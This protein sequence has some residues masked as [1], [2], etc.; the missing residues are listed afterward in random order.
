MRLNMNRKRAKTRWLVAGLLML[1]AWLVPGCAG[2][3]GPVS[4]QTYADVLPD[5]MSRRAGFTGF[6]AEGTIAA[7]REGESYKLP[8]SL[9]VSSD[10]RIEVKGEIS[11]FLLPFSGQFRLVS[12]DEATL[13]YADNGIYDLAQDPDSQAALR[14][15]ILSLVGGGDWLVWWL[16][17]SGCEVEWGTICRGVQIKLEPDS[18]LS[19]ISRWV[20]GTSDGKAAFEAV[21]G[22]RDPGTLRVKTFT[23]TLHPQDIAVSVTYR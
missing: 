3:S 7:S 13:L 6:T 18:R 9:T 2:R 5:I 21:A 19:A 14:A 16:A 10:L 20:V 4:Q 17:D 11:Y 22:E 15:F 12:D 1:S 23:G 8:F